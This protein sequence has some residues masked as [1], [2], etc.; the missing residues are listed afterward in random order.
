MTDDFFDGEW[1]LEEVRSNVD[2][3][4]NIEVSFEGFVAGDPEADSSGTT[5]PET[6]TTPTQPVAPTTPKSALGFPSDNDQ[7]MQSLEV[8][9][10]NGHDEVVETV[11]ALVLNNGELPRLVALDNPEMYIEATERSV[12]YYIDPMAQ[13]VARQ[14]NG[15]T[16]DAVIKVHT[17]PNGSTRPSEKDKQGTQTT[18]DAFQEELGSRNFEFLQGIHAYQPAQVAPS[19]MRDPVAGGNSVS[20]NGERFRHTL[21][22]FDGH[23]QNG[24]EVN[25]L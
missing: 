19:E 11:Y 15:S 16:P 14:C 12:R 10:K 17:H 5:T 3:T 18:R 23:F 4:I 9:G 22:L 24:R 6:P 7:F 20:W 1:E 13:E 25:L 21:A 8:R 2:S